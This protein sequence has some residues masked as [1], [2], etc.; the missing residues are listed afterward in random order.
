MLRN[1]PYPM[2]GGIN[3]EADSDYF[4]RRASEEERAALHARDAKAAEIH[5]KLAVKYAALAQSE[6]GRQQG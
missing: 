3:V 1:P 2:P 4:A 6:R 5:N